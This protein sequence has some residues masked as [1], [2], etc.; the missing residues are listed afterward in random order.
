MR[1]RLTG[2]IA[3]L[4][5]LSL[6]P[7]ALCP[8]SFAMAQPDGVPADVQRA[9]K[10]MKDGKLPEAA[11]ALEAM[12][13][14]D[15]D[16]P[17]AWQSLGMCYHRM[18]NWEKAIAAHTRAAEFEE[19]RKESLYNVA[20]AKAMSGDKPGAVLALRKAVEAGFSDAGVLTRDEDLLSLRDDKDFRAI[21]NAMAANA[22]DAGPAAGPGDKRAIVEG[23]LGAKL[24]AAVLEAGQ[25]S[26]FSGTILVAK[27]GTIILHK[28]YGLADRAKS[29]PIDADSVFSIGSV[30]KAF[31]AAAILALEQDGKLSVSDP[32]SKHLSGIPADKAG[33]TIHHLL[34]H[35]A[36]TIDYIDRPGEG[37]DFAP[38]QKAEAFK[39]I[40]ESPLLFAPGQRS[41]YSNGGY[42][43]LAMVIE[44]ASGDT[45]PHFVRERLFKRAGM[46][47]SGFYGETTWEDSRVARGYGR[48][49]VNGAKA[50]NQWPSPTWALI[51]S[52]GI[53]SSA[54]DLNTWMLAME[55]D[56][57]LN[58]AARAKMFTAHVP[59]GAGG[60]GEGY[61]W[62]IGQSRRGTP[63]RNVGGANEF[64]FG[65]NIFR[66][67][68]ENVTLIVTCN[69]G[70]PDAL[71]PVSG[72][73]RL[74]I[75]D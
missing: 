8:A 59:L 40:M 5:F 69:A 48:R 58:A 60:G 10:L 9:R 25:K 3:P 33:I 51:G 32:I 37:G 12:V 64:G 30:T 71:E 50:P 73:L 56:R 17:L 53:V 72:A 62:M 47:S 2:L 22:A 18:K 66:Y 6:A 57:V 52:G 15:S 75:F 54:S 70:S 36:G 41:E 63:V 24:D 43:L 20:C 55:S 68:E 74:A 65:A 39:R 27:E 23:A 67:V 11:A 4:L 19:V 35:S 16:R 1:T 29:T 49:D 14:K 28:G 34:T 42:V 45:Y 61:G 46:S 13:A 44:S 38:I 31:T 26:G 21:Q 7:A